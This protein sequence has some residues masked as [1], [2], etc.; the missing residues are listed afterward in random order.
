MKRALSLILALLFVLSGMT[1]TSFATETAE[2]AHASASSTSDTDTIVAYMNATEWAHYANTPNN[3]GSDMQYIDVI[4][5]HPNQV[6]NA[7]PGSP[8]GVNVNSSMQVHRNIIRQYNPNIKFVFCLSNQN[9]ANFESWLA[10]TTTADAFAAALVGI[11]QAW[12]YDG[13]D[14]DFEFPSNLALRPNFVYLYASLRTRLN[15]LS[16]S[17][18]KQYILTLAPPCSNWAW[19]KFD[20]C[21]LA[22]Y[23]DWFNIMNYDLYC[24]SLFNGYTHHH[25]PTFD[26]WTGAPFGKDPNTGMN[27][28][29]S[30]SADID[31]YLSQGISADKIVPGC[32]LYSREWVGAG[33]GVGNGLCAKATITETNYHYD[34]IV[35][36][37]M[38]GVNGLGK[39]GFT[40]YWDDVSKAGWLYNPS[41][42]VFLT[43]DDHRS[44]HYKSELVHWQKCRGLMVFDYCTTDGVDLFRQMKIWLNGGEHWHILSSYACGYNYCALCG[45]EEGSHSF[46]DI[47]YQD[48]KSYHTCTVCG[49]TVEVIKTHEWGEWEILTEPTCTAKGTKIRYCTES[50]C[51]ASETAEVDALGHNMSGATVTTEPTCTT[52]GVQTATCGRCGEKVTEEIDA[53]GHLFGEWTDNGNDTEIRICSRCNATETRSN[54][55]YSQYWEAQRSLID[56]EYTVEDGDLVAKGTNNLTNPMVKYINKNGISALDGFKVSITPDAAVDSLSLFWTSTFDRYNDVGEWA[57]DINEKGPGQGNYIYG[58]L[59]KTVAEGEY[60]YQLVFCDYVNLGFY[61]YPGTPD[62]GVYDQLFYSAVSNGEFWGT[63]NVD[64]NYTMGTTLNVELFNRYNNEDASWS[65]GW[66]VNGEKVFDSNFTSAF[67]THNE[68]F[69]F[70]V[71]AYTEGT[72]SAS[73]RIESIEDDDTTWDY[74]SH[75]HAYGEY[76]VTVEPTCLEDGLEVATCSCGKTVERVVSALGHDWTEFESEGIYKSRTCRRCQAVDT[77][78]IEDYTEHWEGQRSLVDLEFYVDN[79]VLQV[80]S[81]GNLNYPMAKLLNKHNTSSLDGFNVKVTPAQGD[82]TLALLW[83]SNFD[84]YNDVNEWSC[85]IGENGPEYTDVYGTLRKVPS[86]GEY[87]FEMVFC[88]YAD[89]GWYQYPGTKDDGIYDQIMS[90]CISNGEFWGTKNYEVKI[91]MGNQLDVT[92]FNRYDE[93]DASWSFGYIVNGEKVYIADYASAY[94]N[95]NDGYC[96]G[97][98][99]YTAGTGDAAFVIDEIE[100]NT[101]TYEYGVPHEHAFVYTVTTEPTCTTAGSET[102]VCSCGATDVRTVKALG[103]DWGEWV[104]T[105][106]TKTRTCKRCSATET[107]DSLVDYEEYWT[108]SSNSENLVFGVKNDDISVDANA[109]VAG[110]SAIALTKGTV[111]LDGFKTTIIPTGTPTA[112]ALFFTNMPESYDETTE[113]SIAVMGANDSHFIYGNFHGTY[114]EG[115]HGFAIV[116]CDY[117]DLGWYQYP[118]T[119]LDG[120]FDQ[121]MYTAVKNG[122]YWGS[123]NVTKA[124]PSTNTL[125]VEIFNRFDE[126]DASWSLGFIVNG[127]KYYAADFVGAFENN[128]EGFNFGVWAYC[129]NVDAKVGFTIDEINNDDTSA[130]FSMHYHS[131]GEWET[132]TAATCT[133]DGVEARYC[134]CGEKEERTIVALGHTFGD[135]VVEGNYYVRRCIR[136]SVTE[137]QAI[138]EDVDVNDYWYVATSDETAITFTN[139]DGDIEVV[140]DTAITDPMAKILS[141]NLVNLDGFKAVV[142]SNN[143]IANLSFF[144]TN[145]AEKYDEAGE[146]SVAEGQYALYGPFGGTYSAGEFG[147]SI[148]LCDF[149]DLGWYQYPGTKDDG[150]YDQA[151]TSVVKNGEFWG[152]KNYAVSAPIDGTVALELFNCFDEDDAAWSL[153]FYLNGEKVYIT[154]FSGAFESANDGYYFGV[155][156]Y[157]QGTAKVGFV[158]D[159]M[160][161]DP[162][163]ADFGAESQE[164][165]EHEWSEWTVETP[166]TCVVKGVEKRTCNKCFEFETRELALAAHTWGEWTVVTPATTTSKGLERRT[167]SV[168]EATEDRD[169]D[170]L[171]PVSDVVVKLVNYDLIIEEAGSVSYIRVAPGYHTTDSAIKNAAGLL[172]L[173][174]TV[175]ASHR[176]ENGKL[177]YELPS[178]GTYSVWV[179]YTDG[180]TK[181]VS[182]LNNEIMTQVVTLNGPTVTVKNLYGIKD[183][184]I[185]KGAY[186]NYTDV[187][188]NQV[189]RVSKEQ[190]LAKKSYTYGAPLPGEGTYT[191][192][193]RY[194]DTT[195]ESYFTT[196]EVS[197]K[198]PTIDVNGRI[199]NI[200]NIDNIRA[201]RVVEGTYTTASEIKAAEGCR[202][203]SSGTVAKLIKNGVLSVVNKVADEGATAYTVY[204]EYA[205]RWAEIHHVDCQKKTP[206]Y[207][208]NG[209]E[210][211][212]TALEDVKVFR[213]A[214][215][216]YST[217]A[218]VKG[219]AGSRYLRP[220]DIADNT[221]ELTGLSGTYT[222]YVEY[223]DSSANIIRVTF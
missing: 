73:F 19:E 91:P 95:V 149:V 147:L 157:T 171:P 114:L 77:R 16:A 195:R 26:N 103:H 41:G 194:S 105:G 37:Y 93:D 116:F 223:S 44:V 215:G 216:S 118:G 72:G 107:R 68:G 212:F 170:M 35:T 60:T 58:T 34:F 10:N 109:G 196:F 151:M 167:C 104:V 187:K 21:G 150:I 98:F 126:D 56:L 165:C 202:T 160:A 78:F 203:F 189:V 190:D 64:V 66:I 138:N 142:E 87:T 123:K 201:I 42:G 92:L 97:V 36:H 173:N 137:K 48:G 14:I 146:W 154:D 219:A 67:E 131:F 7:Y 39:N 180:T 172:S 164:I 186:T 121:I 29:G 200:S 159:E 62:D 100:G 74:G 206:T 153:G 177:V 27:V 59:R 211:T 145:M 83:T 156:A 106:A 140:N 213:Y 45:F 168:C 117:I 32:G 125:D 192:L 18:G 65:L 99:A 70:G 82:A 79:G 115:E 191:L 129:E 76:V 133:E 63:K 193:V 214:P 182:G 141:K 221:V 207:V 15:Q 178:A 69:H 136:C 8:L 217:A 90:H 205:D 176:D 85:D 5:Y 84:Y 119:K 197:V 120:N 86:E 158:L 183:F 57:T 144:W 204:V 112:L 13:I 94:K 108:T 96:F 2:V 75:T 71:L 101:S 6:A 51:G 50:D 169:I 198:H 179:K 218:E 135:W 1:L 46:G 174:A 127:E 162:T 28:G 139:N 181:I 130:D 199:I 17:T 122:E 163:T 53:L 49:Q 25:T 132:V 128:N 54:L 22:P 52:K 40:Y 30:V 222:F 12:D 148:T 89:L 31:L 208:K 9:I 11:V 88:D 210:I 113:M 111:N 38:T 47:F 55:D 161:G 143:T 188:N 220:A 20:M 33:Q 209:N 184:F 152:N 3:I 81:E 24:G 166:S 43:F 185:A 23:V 110:P 102:G 175:I 155:I 124:I 4:N 134:A 80:R 61:T